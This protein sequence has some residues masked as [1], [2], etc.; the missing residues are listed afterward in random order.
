MGSVKKNYKS[1]REN[2]LHGKRNSEE[3]HTLFAIVG[4]GFMP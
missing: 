4:N 1:K 3:D 2:R